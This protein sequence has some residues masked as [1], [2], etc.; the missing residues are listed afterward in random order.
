MTKKSSNKMQCVNYL[1]QWE[2][3]AI[4]MNWRII[5]NYFMKAHNINKR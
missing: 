5:R 3:T 1:E 4:K 2:N